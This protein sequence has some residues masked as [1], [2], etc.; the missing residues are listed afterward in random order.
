MVKIA[1]AYDRLARAIR[2]FSTALNGM[3]AVKVNSFTRLTGNLALLSAMDSTMFSNML[4]VIESRSGVF[5]NL[6]KVQGA[7][8]AKRPGVNVG[9]PG[10]PGVTTSKKDEQIKDAKGETQLQK[11]DKIYKVMVE[12]TGYTKSIDEHLQKPGTKKN[13]DIGAKGDD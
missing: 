6:L 4:R 1:G 13:E 2:N 10:G 11:L 7:E 12:M 9:G 5:A 8:L 3:D